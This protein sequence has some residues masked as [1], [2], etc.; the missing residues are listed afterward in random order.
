MRTPLL[1]AAVLA[2]SVVLTA[3]GGTPST[4]AGASASP[5]PSATTSDAATEADFPVTV[6]SGDGVEV[7]F[8]A[9]PQRI[10]SISPTATETLFA[11]G[12]GDQVVAVDSLSYYPEEAP[13]TDIVAFEPN[14]EAIA[15]YDPD[16][17]IVGFDTNDVVAGLR[18]LDIPTIVHPAVSTIDDAWAQMVETGR[19]TGHLAEAEALV[20]DLQVEVEDLVASV[21]PSET[22]LTY[23]HELDDQYYSATSTT[24]IGQIYALFGLENVADPHDPDGAAFGYPQLSAEVIIDADPDLIFL[25]SGACCQQDADTVAARPGW[26]DIAAVQS[27]ALTLLD[28]DVVSRWGPRIVEFVRTVAT[29]VADASAAQDEA[30]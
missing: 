21:P 2:A 27:G 5:T 6:T 14:V 16:L 13:V 12:A 18:S 3:C 22:T 17:V 15:T 19:I 23:Y 10:V 25:A 4:E 29:A 1:T 20:A 11:V 30:A 28:D 8:D 9:A 26:G 24:F 7:T